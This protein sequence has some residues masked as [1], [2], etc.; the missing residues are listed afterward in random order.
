M[1]VLAHAGS[2]EGRRRARCAT[3][4]TIPPPGSSSTPRAVPLVRPSRPRRGRFTVAPG[5]DLPERPSPDGY[6]LVGGCD[7]QEFEPPAVVVR[8]VQKPA[9]ALDDGSRFRRKAKM[10]VTCLMARHCRLSSRP[11]LRSRKGATHSAVHMQAPGRFTTQCWRPAVQVL[12]RCRSTARPSGSRPEAVQSCPYPLVRNSRAQRDNLESASP[13]SHSL[14]GNIR[15]EVPLRP[16]ARHRSSLSSAAVS[17]SA[18]GLP[19]GDGGG[20]LIIPGSRLAVR[21][22]SG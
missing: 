21:G 16:L 19:M 20:G 18:R 13:P 22:G 10:Q 14:P 1:T 9:V 3:K 8:F 6:G 5:H 15:T 4:L 7:G 12:R 2:L 11:V 17:L